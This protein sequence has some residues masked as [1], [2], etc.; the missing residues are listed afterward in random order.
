MIST[1]TRLVVADVTV[2][3]DPALYAAAH[4]SVSR[5]RRE[6]TDRLLREEDRWRSLGAEWLLRQALRQIGVTEVRLAFG[7]KQKPY[8]PDTPH[9]HFNLSHSGRYA[10]C[11]LSDVPVG[12]DIEQVREENPR[13]AVRF[14]AAEYADITA[15]PT[16]ERQRDFFF[17]YWT[18]KE[19][20]MKAVGLGLYLPLDSFAIDL[21]GERIRVT[22]VAESDRYHFREYSQ[23]DGYKCALCTQGILQGDIP[24]KT[25]DLRECIEK[26]L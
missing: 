8:L 6:K 5:D 25:V 23:M 9:I 2:L 17:R 14:S 12:C 11:A 26:G 7:E 1:D 24:L 4:D 16:P 19:S 15:Q 13:I 21:S 18:L 20:Y 3:S 22:G 10:L